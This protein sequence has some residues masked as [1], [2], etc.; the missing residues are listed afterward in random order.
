MV[1]PKKKITSHYDYLKKEFNL[2]SQKAITWTG[3]DGVKLRVFLYLPHDFHGIKKVSFS[4]S[5][6]WWT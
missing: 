3:E 1:K 4:S 6:S 2:P 5:N